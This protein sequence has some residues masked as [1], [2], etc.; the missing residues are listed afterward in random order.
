MAEPDRRDLNFAS[1][2]DVTA[3]IEQLA[4]GEV[5]VT[6]HHSFAEIVRH[7]AITNEML[8]GGPVPPKL[9]WYM[10]LAMPFMRKSI[11]ENPVKPG[12]KLPTDQM[13]SFFWPTEP[14]DVTEAVA[15]FNSSAE[16]YET[17]GPPSTHPIFGSA[18]PETINTML[19]RH[20][21]MH[22]GFAHPA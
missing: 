6:G 11:L 5:R 4:G 10:R 13:Q 20:A 17:Q 9:P 18:E 15:R 2:A 14:I 19:L 1:M 21:A 3:D 22:L 8:T 7:L 12:F 16:R